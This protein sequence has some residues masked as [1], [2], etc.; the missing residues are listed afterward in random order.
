M[1][2]YSGYQGTQS[3]LSW[4]YRGIL[5]LGVLFLLGRTFELTIIKGGY[6]RD[7]SE[8][9]R[10][11]RITL[12]APRGRIMARGG[13]ILAG[14]REIKKRIIFNAQ[15]GFEKTEEIKGALPEEIVSEYERYY[16][17]GEKAAHL[18]GYLGEINEKEVNKVNPQCSEK[19]PRKGSDLIGRS[20]LE[21]FY[22]CLLRGTDGEELIEVDT[23]GRK[24]RVLGR[25]EPQAGSD[26]KTN[27]DYPLQEKV[28]GLFNG[29][30]GGT[31]VSDTQGQ[32][33]A[34]YSSPSFDPNIF[35]GSQSDKEKVA[36]ILK[37]SSL[38]L[39]NRMIGGQF[40]PG[41]VFKPL[42]TIASLEEGKITGNYT[43]ND[44]GQIEVKTLYGNFVYNNWY[45]TQYGGREGVI[46]LVKALA[47]S[48]DTFFYTI[49]ELTGID[50]LVSWAKKFGFD[51]ETGI[52]LSG[53][54]GG[55]VPSPEWKKKVKNEDWFL[56][57]TYHFSIGQGDLAVTPIEINRYFAAIANNG[58][59]CTPQIINKGENPKCTD[60][61]IQKENL[62]LIKKGMTAACSVGGTGFT[63]FGFSP[64][65]ACKTGTAETNEDGKT[66]AWF[67]FFAP[68]DLPEIV[69]TVLLERGGEGS[70]VAGPIAREIADFWF[71]K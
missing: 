44:Q 40:H 39:F 53:E 52:D 1:E 56:G 58:K 45:F 19:G 31:I 9:N 33:L 16:N 36:E 68:N 35:W 65:V 51:K 8:G 71:K 66:H 22:D 7:L 20:G 59:I 12:S 4:F 2:P 63:F 62:D 42:V 49:G 3:W 38:P 25:R 15:T 5:I 37:D 26:L 47:R 69:T 23:Q 70:K 32:I 67:S 48:T 54:I 61:K 55:L 11:R 13:E 41:S 21:E 27:I 64:Q 14:N 10:I 28:A 34:L 50:D 43:F 17:L 6:F 57:N 30:K 24:I 29:E 60:L 18:T 46:N